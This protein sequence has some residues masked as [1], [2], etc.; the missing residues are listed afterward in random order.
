MAAPLAEPRWLV[1]GL[2]GLTGSKRG[3]RNAGHDN[4][5]DVLTTVTFVVAFSI[6]WAMHHSSSTNCRSMWNGFPGGVGKRPSVKRRR[7][8]SIRSMYVSASLLR[9]R[10][11][12]QSVWRNRPILRCRSMAR[13]STPARSRRAD[14]SSNRS[15]AAREC[16]RSAS[17]RSNAVGSSRSRWTQLEPRS[18]NRNDSFSAN[19][20]ARAM[21]NEENGPTYSASAKPPT[22]RHDVI[23][24]AGPSPTIRRYA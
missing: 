4:E 15:S 13:A 21:S 22:S 6:H 14:A 19:A 10:S 3:R 23:F 20:A 5:A 17:G 16:I 7:P 1:S 24:A 8:L 18:P 11:S 9:N 2:M 12:S